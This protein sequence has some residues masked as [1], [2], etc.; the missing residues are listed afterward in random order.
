MATIIAGEFA[1]MAELEPAAAALIDANF[2]AASVVV[3]MRRCALRARQRAA[4][5]N[6]RPQSLNYRGPL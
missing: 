3:C 4:H 5:P 2:E 6:T 1:T